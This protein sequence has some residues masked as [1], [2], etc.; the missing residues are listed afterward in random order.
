MV[1]NKGTTKDVWPN[2][3]EDSQLENR[4]R[5]GCMNGNKV[6]LNAVGFEYR[7]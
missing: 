5:N 1:M 4:E 6:T 2:L 3:W 7:S